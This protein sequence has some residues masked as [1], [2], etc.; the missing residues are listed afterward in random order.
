MVAQRR[1]VLG[2][3]GEVV[4]VVLLGGGGFLLVLQVML[5]IQNMRTPKISDV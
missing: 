1:V 2:V 3:P 4:T 5:K